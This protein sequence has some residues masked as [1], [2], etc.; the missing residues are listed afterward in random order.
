VFELKFVPF[1]RPRWEDDIDKLAR[2]LSGPTSY[3]ARTIDPNNGKDS[4]VSKAGHGQIS[5]CEGTLGIFAAVGKDD[6][7][8]VE[9]ASLRR[10]LVGNESLMPRFLHA[11]GKVPSQRNGG[12]GC[13]MDFD[14]ASLGFADARSF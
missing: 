10:G 1:A 2:I 9:T 3:S 4:D 8:A 11:W 13:D 12:T 6:S 7:A 5:I 14:V